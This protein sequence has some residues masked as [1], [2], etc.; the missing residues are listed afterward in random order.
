MNV[1]GKK[2]M[3]RRAIALIEEL[4]LD[5]LRPISILTALSSCVTVLKTLT[6]VCELSAD[7]VEWET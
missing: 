2:T 3:V 1:A 4:S 7:S 6:S 5:I